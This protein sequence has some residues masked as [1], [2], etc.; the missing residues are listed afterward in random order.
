MP[1]WQPLS[2]MK[3]MKNHRCAQGKNN[4]YE[5]QANVNTLIGSLRERLADAVFASDPNLRLKKLDRV[6]LEIQRSDVPIRPDDGSTP[7][8]QYPRKSKFH[9]NKNLICDLI[10]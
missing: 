5:Y 10:H 1:T 6:M 8:F 4:K 9:H 2:K 7:R 3:P